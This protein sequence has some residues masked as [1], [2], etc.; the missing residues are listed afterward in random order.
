MSIHGWMFGHKSRAGTCGS[1]LAV[2]TRVRAGKRII[3]KLRPL[4]G[5]IGTVQ[6]LVN[7]AGEALSALRPDVHALLRLVLS[8][9]HPAGVHGPRPVRQS[10]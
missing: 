7:G 8:R 4:D 1:R 9:R 5:R 3:K 6:T 10:G 2:R